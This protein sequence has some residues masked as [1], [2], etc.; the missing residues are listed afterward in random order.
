MCGERVDGKL[1]ETDQNGSPKVHIEREGRNQVWCG[2]K[3]M[4]LMETKSPNIG[5]KISLVLS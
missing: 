1:G 5:R 3:K 2:D 4:C